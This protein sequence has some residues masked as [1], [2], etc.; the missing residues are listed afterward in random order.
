[1][2]S[3]VLVSS[4]LTIVLCFSLIVGSTFALFTSEDKF[5]IS[6]TSGKVN[7]D[8]T[9][10]I[11]GVYSAKGDATGTLVDENG[12]TYIHEEQANNTFAN[13]GTVAM[14]GANLVIDRLTPGDKVVLNVAIDNKSNV[15]IQYRY[16]IAVTDGE[17]LATGM[18]VTVDGVAYEG[19]KSCKSAWIAAESKEAIADKE[20]AIELPIAAGN[21]Y[22]DRT[23]EYAVLVEAVQANGVVT[24]AAEVELFDLANNTVDGASAINGDFDGN[25]A[26]YSFANTDTTKANAGVTTTGGTLKNFSVIGEKMGN[27]G[28]RALYITGLTEDLHLENVDL[29]GTYAMNVNASGNTNSIYAEDCTFNGWTSYGSANEVVFTNCS[30]GEAEGYANLRPYAT[31]TL[32]GCDF[33]EGF[34]I[35]RDSGDANTF[36]I[37]LNNCTVDGVAVTADNFA[38]LLGGDL[39]SVNSLATSTKITVEVD[40]VAVDWNNRPADATDLA[41]ALTSDAENIYVILDGDM[42]LAITSLGTITGGSGEYKL[43]G[44]DTESIVI[45]LNG[46]TLNITTTYWSAIGAKNPNAT[47]TIK[48]GSMISTGNSAGTW[49]AWDLRFSNCNYVFE[50][51][52]FEKAVAL[53]NAGKSVTMKN[54]TIKDTHNVDT[55]ALWITAEGQNVTIDGL[56]IDMLA[57]TDGR[58]IKIDDQY[59]SNASKVTLSIKDA[60]FKTE[61][62]SAILVK[63]PAGADITLNNVNIADVAA[64]AVN[65]V[66]VDGDALAYADLV[67][68]TGGNKINEP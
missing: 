12:A 45:D 15:A 30:F 5:D 59:V 32:E 37:A 43:G 50:N 2:K 47:I 41:A 67:N 53:D 51:V 54:V 10:S 65:P 49:N 48:N 16:T 25:H 21:F 55:Y 56:T 60:T 57:C 35:T 27:K 64:D 14:D 68:V 8:A 24:G 26:V 19:L 62:K 34:T 40:G 31:T 3:K 18:V 9:A 4:I 52:T 63:S 6:I 33:E 28:F 42:D 22:Q 58:G 36:T 7:I 46:K 61:E 13:G 44:E 1:M 11:V 20:I 66:W 39:Y 29:E 17:L 38:A 23:V